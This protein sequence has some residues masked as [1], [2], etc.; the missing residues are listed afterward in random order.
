MATGF[1]RV[2]AETVSSYAHKY[3]FP[4]T[5]PNEYAET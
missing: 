1:T 5:Q 2:R 3:E 4:S